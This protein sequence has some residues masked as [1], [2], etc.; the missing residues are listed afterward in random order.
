MIHGETIEKGK[1]I[2]DSVGRSDMFEERGDGVGDEYAV[3]GGRTSGKEIDF[4]KSGE[5]IIESK[6]EEMIW[7]GESVVW[8]MVGG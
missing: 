7:G 5:S 3:K 1:D 4:F 6:V 2:L 8:G